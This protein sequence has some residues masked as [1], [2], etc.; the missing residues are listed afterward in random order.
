MVLPDYLTIRAQGS[1]EPQ[2]GGASCLLGETGMHLPRAGRPAAPLASWCGDAAMPARLRT[3]FASDEGLRD[4]VGLIRALAQP[5]AF[6]ECAVAWILARTPG[7]LA[8]L[9]VRAA[10]ACSATDLR[11]DARFARR[12]AE[13]YGALRAVLLVQSTNA[14]DAAAFASFAEAFGLRD[15]VPDRLY[16]V[17]GEEDDMA[18]RCAWLSGPTSDT[19]AI[20][21]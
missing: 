20:A 9:V 3:L 17:T 18:L 13:R 15:V 19:A 7:G 6:G 1:A 2:A 11:D 21:A 16:A 14:P 10:R 5:D 12:Q 4:P 8:S